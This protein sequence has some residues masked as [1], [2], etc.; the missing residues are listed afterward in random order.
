[1][2][3]LSGRE[4]ARAR[5]APR[6]RGSPG[7]PSPW[8]TSTVASGMSSR[9]WSMPPLAE[10]PPS[11]TATGT[12]ASGFWRA[13]KAT[14]IRHSRS[15]RSARRWRCRGP[16][17]LPPCRRARRCAAEGRPR[18]PAAD[19]QSGEPR[20]A[21]VAARRCAARSR[22]WSCSHEHVRGDARDDAEAQSPV[23]VQ[24]GELPSMLRRR[25]D[26]WTACSGCRDRAAGPR[27]GG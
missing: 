20:R 7:T 27:R 6:S 3:A 1:M 15:R 18:A 17:R 4:D 26:A 12:I 11:S 16:P 25:S 10:M 8:S 23:H 13:M 19:R 21:R 9:R 22:T 14:R 2:P 5:T 24:P